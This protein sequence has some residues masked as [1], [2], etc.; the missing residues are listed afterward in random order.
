MITVYTGLMSAVDG[1]TMERDRIPN[2]RFLKRNFFLANTY[3]AIARMKTFKAVLAN[4][5]IRLLTKNFKIGAI[6]KACL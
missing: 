2:M 3:P 5:T 1:I 6:S 4:E